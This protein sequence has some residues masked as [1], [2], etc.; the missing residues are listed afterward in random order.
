[1]L[2][3]K[4]GPFASGSEA[5]DFHNLLHPCWT[6]A[7]DWA[8]SQGNGSSPQQGYHRLMLFLPQVQ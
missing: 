2:Q 4:W 5:A 3:I 1:M 6:I 7:T 8:G